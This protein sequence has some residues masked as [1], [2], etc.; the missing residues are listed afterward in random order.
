[1]SEWIKLKAQDGH[2]LD[3]YVARPAGEPVGALVLIQEI[4]GVNKHIRGIADG[5]AKDGFLV[6]APA[7]FDRYEKNVDLIYEGEDKEHGYSL[8]PK[9]LSESFTPALNDIAAAFAYAREAGKKVGVLGFCI[10]GL[11]TWISSTRGESYGF[12]PAC[13]VG[14]YAG[15]I[16][17]FATEQPTCPVLLHFGADDSHIGSDQVDAVRAAH[18]EVEVLVYEGAGHGFNCDMRADF[19]PES[20]ALARERTLA[21][22]KHHLA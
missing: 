1:M 8:Y 20:A 19:E 9:L 21:F 17:S 4:F 6:V 3:A 11:L 16:G 2:E 7:L 10:G 13:A 14:Y 12:S 15:G 18:P 22:L 5:Y